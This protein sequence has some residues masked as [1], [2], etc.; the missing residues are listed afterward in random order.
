MLF[1]AL[2]V[3]EMSQNSPFKS[4]M[5][6]QAYL[7]STKMISVFINIIQL[8]SNFPQEKHIDGQR[9]CKRNYFMKTYP[10]RKTY[11]CCY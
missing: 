1:H 7:L 4:M 9:T 2:K 11:F 3:T 10:A 5:E 6:K 8:Q